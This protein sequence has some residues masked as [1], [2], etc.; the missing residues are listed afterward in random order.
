[1]EKK[2]SLEV[3]KPYNKRTLRTP[4]GESFQHILSTLLLLK[5]PECIR[6]IKEST[7]SNSQSI[8]S[9]RSRMYKVHK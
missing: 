3:V 9:Q 1:M 4:R 2:R 8:H 6:S 5:D 7:D